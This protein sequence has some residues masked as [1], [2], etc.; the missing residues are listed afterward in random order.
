MRRMRQALLWLICRIKS[1]IYDE[2]F[3]NKKNKDKDNNK[4]LSRFN[5]DKTYKKIRTR[6]SN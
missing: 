5:T 3:I 4:F 2:L 1:I 6:K